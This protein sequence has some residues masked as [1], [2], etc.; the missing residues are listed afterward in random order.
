MRPTYVYA[1]AAGPTAWVPIDYLQSAFGIGLGFSVTN[2]ASLT[3]SVQ[4]TFGSPIGTDNQTHGV[5]L[6]QS[7]TTVT[8]TDLGPWN[9][10]TNGHGLLTGDS[11]QIQGSTIGVDGIYTVTVTSA[12]QYTYTV[13]NSQS[14]TSN[15]ALAA[16]LRVFNHVSLAGIS[17]RADGNYAYPPRMI[18]LNVTAYTSGAAILEILQ[19]LGHT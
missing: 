6:S 7:T 15:S 14:A 2:A 1:N 9:D 18:R 4:H 13:S 10:A 3:A 8:V 19:G 16:G 12:T 11:V 5:I 17:S